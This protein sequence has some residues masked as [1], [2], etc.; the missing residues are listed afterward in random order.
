MCSWIVATKII[1]GNITLETTG[2]GSVML[3][4]NLVALLSSVI[5]M[6]T[7]SLRNPDNFDLHTLN[8]KLTLVKDGEVFD[9]DNFAI[10]SLLS[11]RAGK[12]VDDSMEGEESKDEVPRYFK[13][14]SQ[15]RAS[16]GDAEGVNEDGVENTELEKWK[17]SSFRLHKKEYLISISLS[18]GLVVI[19][20]L[21]SIPIDT[22]SL[23][24]FRFWVAI[25]MIWCVI[26]TLVVIF[27]PIYEGWDQL[28]TLYRGIMSSRFVTFDEV[29]DV[30]LTVEMNDKH[31]NPM[32]RGL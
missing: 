27:L 2:N 13:S 5:I 23:D 15:A 16:L 30:G 6:V 7:L 14:V 17:K 31:V 11:P 8:N 32:H 28:K 9:G 29:K 20:P 12:R 24:Y 22:F 10:I 18:V 1:Y 21:L 26:A 4:G 25:A 3:I 19:W